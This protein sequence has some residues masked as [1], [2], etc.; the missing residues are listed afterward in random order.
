MNLLFLICLLF[1]FWIKS[2]THQRE[3]EAK[4]KTKRRIYRKEFDGV[5]WP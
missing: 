5:R 1:R 4:A 3:E 2:H